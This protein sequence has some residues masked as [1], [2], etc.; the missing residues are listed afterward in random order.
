MDCVVPAG[1]VGNTTVEVSVNGGADFTVP[2]VLFSRINMV[3]ISAIA[4]HVL[5]ISGGSAAVV[6][7]SGFNFDMSNVFCVVG[8]SMMEGSAW[9]HATGAVVS[10]SQIGCTMPSRTA[11]MRPLEISLGQNSQ[12]THSGVQVEYVSEGKLETV[13]PSAGPST[14]GV[15]V[16]VTGQDFV[17]GRTACRFGKVQVV[18]AQVLSATEARCA[19][20]VAMRGSITIDLTTT[21]VTDSPSTPVYVGSVVYV[22]QSPRIAAVA[23]TPQTGAVYGGTVVTVTVANARDGKP[24]LCRFNTIDVVST[25]I[26]DG[27]ANCQSPAG[28][29]GNVTLSVSQNGQDFTGIPV[30][31]KNVARPNVTIALPTVISTGGGGVTISGTGYSK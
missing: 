22:A 7:G 8:G 23:Y 19:T 25:L 14:G 30:L 1:I 21:Y 28:L 10:A 5:A 17:A 4:P 11:G 9:A 6:S 27:K 13:S 2:K 26:E 18:E 29:A 15:V 24:V 16:T 31:F 20:P 3:N 12:L